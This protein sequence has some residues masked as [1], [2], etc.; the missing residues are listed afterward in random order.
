LI[1]GWTEFLR[2]FFGKAGREPALTTDGCATSRILAAMERDYISKGY[3][4]TPMLSRQNL[5]V[6]PFQAFESV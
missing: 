3:I 1:R 4:G 6:I 5:K 2:T